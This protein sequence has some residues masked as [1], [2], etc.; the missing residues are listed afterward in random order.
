MKIHSEYWNAETSW[1]SKKQFVISCIKT[2]PVVR[3]RKRDGTRRNKSKNHL[4]IFIFNQKEEV[5]CKTGFLNMLSISKTFTRVALK[6]ASETGLM[7]PDKHIP[8]NKLSCNSLEHIKNHILKFLVY[9]SHYSREITKR[10]YLGN[11]LNIFTMYSLYVDECEKR[12]SNQEKSGHIPKFSMKI[13]IC[14]F[15]YQI[16]TLVMFA[17]N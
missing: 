14:R 6:I 9:E 7:T 12:K 17:T 1:D 3:K 4:F 16:M 10:K 15:T 8:A 2:K 11:H 13:L 5:I